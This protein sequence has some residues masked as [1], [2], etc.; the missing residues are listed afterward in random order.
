M[1][2][3]GGKGSKMHHVML[4]G[5]EKA[6]KTF[7]LYSRLKQFITASTKIRTRS[8]ECKYFLRNYILI[9]SIIAF[10]YE[11]VDLGSSTVA[12]WDLPGRENLRMLWPNFYR[13]IDFSGLIYLIN[14][15]NKDTLAEAVKVMH[16]LLS[17]EELSD[18]LVL[19]VL[20][21]AKKDFDEFNKGEKTNIEEVQENT[22]DVSEDPK[23][24]LLVDQIKKDIYFDLLK[25]NKDMYVLDIYDEKVTPNDHVK[26][27]NFFKQFILKFE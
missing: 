25:Q 10:N 13:N 3:C 16:D 19:V 4:A 22:A 24:K 11:E 15:D 12:I 26:T 23:N 2:G 20:N 8:T 5:I 6:G 18:V 17:E 21:C 27:R 1:G 9:H 14:Y 7:F